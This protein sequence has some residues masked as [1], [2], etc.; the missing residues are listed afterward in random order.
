MTLRL[1]KKDREAHKH[2]AVYIYT[3]MQK[4]RYTENRLR[5]EASSELGMCPEPRGVLPTAWLIDQGLC[6]HT[7]ILVHMHE[8]TAAHTRRL[9][10]LLLASY[11]KWPAD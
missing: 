7:H 11:E 1:I 5:H 10:L 4:Q 3:D 9:L 6:K 8:N 2:T